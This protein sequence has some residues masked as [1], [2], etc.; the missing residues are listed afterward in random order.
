MRVA[1]FILSILTCLGLVATP[2]DARTKETVASL[3]RKGFHVTEAIVPF[4]GVI[5]FLEKGRQRYVCIIG[6]SFHKPD[7]ECTR[8]KR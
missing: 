3:I 2:L 5:L 6:A 8:L 7:E 1:K 4:D